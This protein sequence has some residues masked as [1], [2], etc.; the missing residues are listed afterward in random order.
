[1]ECCQYAVEQI[2]VD[3]DLG[4][5]ERDGAGMADN[6][7]ADFDQSAISSGRSVPCRKTPRF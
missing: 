1:M 5:L 3:R 6:A 2:T 4:E 7:C